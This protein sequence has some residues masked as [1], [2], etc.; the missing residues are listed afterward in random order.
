M[1]VHAAKRPRWATIETMPATFQPSNRGCPIPSEPSS[2]IA[3]HK[4]AKKHTCFTRTGSPLAASDP[5]AS[6]H[7]DAGA[8]R[9]HSMPNVRGASLKPSSSDRSSCTSRAPATLHDEGKVVEGCTEPS[10]Q[11]FASRS[12]EDIFKW[13]LQ[14]KESTTQ[15]KSCTSAWVC[16]DC[17]EIR[18]FMVLNSLD[19]W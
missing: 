13:L 10:A 19:R 4:P 16:K 2:Q 14:R 7:A 12:S 17:R 9:R 8:V 3:P 6:M 1:K 18:V 15:R 11:L 5:P